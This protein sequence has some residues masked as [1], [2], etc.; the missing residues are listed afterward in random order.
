[1]K[2][3]LF[4]AML[5]IAVS[6]CRKDDIPSGDGSTPPEQ[7][8]PE[9]PGTPE[10]PKDPETPDNPGTP[11][12]PEEDKDPLIGDY[13]YDDG[14]WSTSRK[15]GKNIIGIIY[16]VGDPTAEDAA[17]KADH[18]E[19]THGLAVSLNQKRS[20]WQTG[21][22]QLGTTV[23]DWLAKQNPDQHVPYTSKETLGARNGYSNTKAIETFNLA[24][25]N[26]S[27]KV[28]AV[29]N[30]LA[31]R[32]QVPVP[33]STS[34]WY[35]PSAKELSLMC[36]GEFDDNLLNLDKPAIDMRTRL[37][38][39][40]TETPEAYWLSGGVYW[41]SSEYDDATTGWMGAWNV[42]FEDGDVNISFKD[43]SSGICRYILAF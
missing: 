20:A 5:A 40:L 3:L 14:T 19:C 29:E 8:V 9:T 42:Y 22:E 17:L 26:A 13:L 16:W 30:V 34:G 28:D 43:F 39:I 35:L 27:W 12:D 38:Q 7:E 4:L 31:Y 1:M 33:E 11:G 15:E 6:S 18:P 32:A 37:N 2:R 24:E 21:F 25:E 23:S 36:T 41:S 10:E